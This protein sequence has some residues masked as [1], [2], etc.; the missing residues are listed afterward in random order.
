MNKSFN[1]YFNNSINY[2]K[3]SLK[4]EYKWK[5][6]LLHNNPHPSNKN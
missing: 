4:E 2:L 1:K 3:K 6:N 5:Q